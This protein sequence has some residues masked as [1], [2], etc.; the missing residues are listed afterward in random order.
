MRSLEKY[1]HFALGLS[2]LAVCGKGY[3]QTGALDS[4][5]WG[6]VTGSSK[7]VP[8]NGNPVLLSSPDGAVAKPNYET[9]NRILRLLANECVPERACGGCDK[10]EPAIACWTDALF[11][12]TRPDVPV[13]N[14]NPIVTL[15]YVCN[16]IFPNVSPLST[17]VRVAGR[18]SL[19]CLAH[20]APAMGL[21]SLIPRP[22]VTVSSN[23]E[24][25]PYNGT[26]TLSWQ[27]TNA[28]NCS[29]RESMM[30]SALGSG[31][32]SSVQVTG[33]KADKDFSLACQGLTPATPMASKLIKVKVAAAPPPVIQLTADPDNV[34]VGESSEVSWTVV[35]DVSCYM[36]LAS[37]EPPMMNPVD[38]TG[39]QNFG[40][41]TDDLSVTIS[42]STAG[43]YVPTSKT[44]TVNVANEP[45]F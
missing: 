39:S 4:S 11:R 34:A 15:P 18:T 45:T 13:V 26:V 38:H 20:F 44:I 7:L 41:L 2:F 36:Q 5:G 3:A 22:E 24:I 27:S 6:K 21:E 12:L 8:Y 23:P 32:S 42:C 25:V 40:P 33:L 30:M 43:S 14:G 16:T 29:L 37:E 28:L 10:E 17:M 19:E 35:G 1:L 31:V 9:Y